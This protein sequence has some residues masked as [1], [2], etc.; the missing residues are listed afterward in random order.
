[1]VAAKSAGP[2]LRHSQ[3]HRGQD[4]GELTSGGRKRGHSYHGPAGPNHPF[5]MASEGVCSESSVEKQTAPYSE[6]SA[7][8]P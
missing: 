2:P 7:A 4:S 5:L 3:P 6:H 8:M 1:L